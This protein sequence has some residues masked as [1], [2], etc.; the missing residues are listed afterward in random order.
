MADKIITQNNML[1]NT[2][3]VEYLEKLAV[4][5][6]TMLMVLQKPV[7]R[8]GEPVLNVD[9]TIKY[10]W[11]PHLPE[12]YNGVGAW[13]G[14]TG[15]YIIERFVDGK[16]SASASNCE[17]VAVMVLDDIGTKSKI[18]PLEPTWI[19]ET[20][21]DNFQWGYTF[22]VDTMPTKGEFC[23]AIN[24]IAKAGY[25]DGGAI[26]AVRNF[27]LPGSVNLKPNKDSFQS[28][29]VEFHPENEFSLEQI[30]KALDV[31]PN[32]ADTASV[33]TV[34][35]AD[36]GED[37]ILT[38]LSDHNAILDRA[39]NTGWYGVLCPNAQ[40]HS[41]N[42][43]M[44][45]YHP[46][47]RSFK[48]FHEHCTHITS[49]VF[50]DWAAG[51]G[52]EQ[53]QA[54]L[55]PE[56][57][58]ALYPEA[59]ALLTPSKMFSSN[60][61]LMRELDLRALGRIQKGDWHKHFAY[62]S[63]NDSYFDLVNRREISRST[64]NA[65]Y[66]HIECRSIHGKKPQIAASI[67]F[68]ERR[69]SVNAKIL[70]NLTYAAGESVYVGREGDI[71][72][73]RWVD[74]RPNIED[75]KVGDI[76]LWTNLLA[77]LVPS[78]KDRNHLL[79]IMAF[80]LKNPKIKINHAVLHVGD[81]GCGK[82]TLWSPFIWSVC[83][84][85]LK[86]RGYM[87]SE[88]I[89]SQWGYDLESEIL[90][91]N[92]LKE[93][94]ASTRRALAN[95]LKPII[96]A[97]PEMLNINRKGLHPYQMANRLFVLAFSNEQIPISLASQDRRWFCIS[98]DAPRMSDDEGKQIW[99]WF[100]AGGF[101]QITAYLYQRDVSKFNP[102]ATP[103]MTEF[104]TNLIEHGRS[105]AESYLVD[106]M[107]NRLSVF[108]D[109]ICGSPFHDLCEPMIGVQI[110]HGVKIPQAALLHAFKEA[111]WT[112]LGLLASADYTNKKHIFAVPSVIEGKSKSEIR[113]MVE[114]KLT[115]V[116]NTK[117]PATTVLSFDTIKRAR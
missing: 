81:E 49:Q 75:T 71:Y 41:D 25:T 89:G 56:L 21:P 13:Y 55:R 57:L 42:N 14:N 46:V 45:R 65:I 34:K 32:E 51:Q 29:L 61:E 43:P 10:T 63:A 44:G 6:E 113:R 27:R 88:T 74:A 105:P 93:P 103:A 52:A 106:L 31:K 77:R 18:P 26:N 84:S 97:P 107:R 9:K 95:K 80:K 53:H 12:H 99:D 98:S 39:N 72:G 1:T 28:E 22:A 104:K 66:R 3:F 117:Q 33:R 73:N 7:T 87:D 114:P 24:A 38:W 86:N 16:L 110:P 64:F 85:N 92:E 15:S 23:A 115:A 83:G 17:Y 101:E 79:N 8:A 90:I 58:T 5:G 40:N 35:I 54:G 70:V 82:D 48:C 30:C 111:G 36:N 19:M 102:G 20:S 67:S 60:E 62:V 11:L 50:L 91:I 69:E 100:N 78:E 4:E 116:E 68:D 108:K 47:T 109:G 76:S 96:A 37:D 2:D 112:D 59:R 94:D